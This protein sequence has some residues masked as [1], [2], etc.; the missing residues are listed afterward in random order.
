MEK[1]FTDQEIDL[2][3]LCIFRK[4]HKEGFFSAKKAL[5]GIGLG[6]ELMN[7]LAKDNAYR[8]FLL[9]LGKLACSEN[10]LSAW[11]EGRLKTG[12]YI[13]AEID[14]NENFINQLFSAEE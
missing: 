4:C 10:S 8:Q 12:E 14:N 3:F 13:K 6:W 5:E 2:V 11:L 7:E 1:N 9:E